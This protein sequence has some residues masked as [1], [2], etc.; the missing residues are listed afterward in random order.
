VTNSI[1][2]VVRRHT[3]GELIGLLLDRHRKLFPERPVFIETGCGISTLYLAEAGRAL[4][5]KIYSCDSNIDKI[6]ALQQRAGERVSN[7][8]F[9]AGDSVYQLHRLGQEHGHVHFLFLDA[10]ASAMHT[11]REFQVIEKALTAGTLLLID[12]A[13]LPGE[14]R[15]LSPCRKGKIIVP[16]LQASA[17]WEV[18]GYPDAGDSMVSAICHDRPDY[19]DPAYEW[20]GYVDPWEWSFENQWVDG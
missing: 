1:D 11:F 13:A 16:Y 14:T 4:E 10:A 18:Q 15:L 8:E 6:R 2:T 12:N 5:A 3:H 19:S 9:L 7:V 17:Y 20:P